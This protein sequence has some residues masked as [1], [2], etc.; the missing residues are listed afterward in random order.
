MEDFK[1]LYNEKYKEEALELVK[2]LVSFKS[3]LDEYRPNTDTPFGVGAKEALTYL[4]DY[5]KKDG[6]ITFNAD[7]Y[8]GDLEFGSGKDVLGLLAHLD[9]VP[10]SG[11]D[12]ISDP[13]TVDI[14]DGKMYGRGV[15]DD[16]GPLVSSYIAMKMLKDQGFEPSKKIRLIF[17]CDEES[18]SRCL[19]HYFKVKEKPT[20]SFSPDA[21]F[22]GIHGEKGNMSYDIL[23]SDDKVIKTFDAGVRYNMV[24]S[25]ATATLNVN[26]EK[27]FNTYLKENNYNGSYTNGVYKVIG[28][29]AHAMCPEEGIN[30]AYILFDFINKYSDSK[31]AK[32]VCQYYAFDTKGEKIGYDSYDD[33]MKS[34]TSNFAIVDIKDGNGKLG[35]NCRLPKN[36]DIKNVEEKV[37]SATTK[38]NFGYKV[39]GA[40]EIHYVEKD[41][42]LMKTLY[43]AYVKVTGDTVNEPTTIGGGTYA[44]ELNDAV[45][46]GPLFPGREDVCHIA[47]EYMYLED[48]DKMTE[49]YYNAIYELT[50]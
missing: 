18:G 34:L 16:K 27:E 4:L 33:V 1:K 44:H 45:A 3:V 38:Y 30:A 5:A 19:E 32:F 17:G 22:P 8:A 41:S 29:G 6:F 21:D 12:W 15:N 31:I 39:L 7:N 23:V 50:K 9:V 13:F 40:S 37:A 24:P 11:Q 42:Y 35:V 2:K 14:R 25:I 48:F 28:K 47:N 20:M 49:I 10:V 46:F 43:D 26:L 36:S